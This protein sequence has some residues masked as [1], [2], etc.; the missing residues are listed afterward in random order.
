MAD[1]AGEG[2]GSADVGVDTDRALILV[3]DLD[4]VT[5]RQLLLIS[6]RRA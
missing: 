4:D 1:V 2:V 3:R 5:Q 6:H